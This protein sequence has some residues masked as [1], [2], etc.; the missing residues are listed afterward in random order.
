MPTY[1]RKELLMRSFFNFCLYVQFPILCI[2]LP[3]VN[4][5]SEQFYGKDNKIDT[6]LSREYLMFFQV[7]FL[8]M[9]IITVAH[10][11]HLM[12]KGHHYEFGRIKDNMLGIFYQGVLY[13]S[14]YTLLN[15]LIVNDN[16]F[17]RLMYFD[18]TLHYLEISCSNV[19]QYAQEMALMF[20]NIICLRLQMF[21][22][23]MAWLMIKYKSPIDIL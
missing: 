2:V 21:P 16:H 7:A 23:I 15:F 14:L 5:L 1:R 6:K 20:T 8:V 10:L 19:T 9:I 12:K 3:L 18:L 4:K 11:Y 13:I 22:L 17:S